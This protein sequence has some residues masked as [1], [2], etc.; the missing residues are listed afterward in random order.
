[1]S[2]KVKH[3]PHRCPKTANYS[4]QST[5]ETATVYTPYCFYD[6]SIPSNHDTGT[7]LI[8][9]CNV[10][11]WIGTIGQEHSCSACVESMYENMPPLRD[12]KRSLCPPYRILLS[13]R[14]SSR[15]LA[16]LDYSVLLLSS[17]FRNTSSSDKGSSP[18]YA[19][20]CYKDNLPASRCLIHF[21]ALQS[22]SQGATISPLVHAFSRV[23]LA[24]HNSTRCHDVR[25]I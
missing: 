7:P 9:H 20:H 2:R 14:R 3:I 6:L 12:L 24:P 10:S 13:L 1:M 18:T 5:T 17:F 19:S 21:D 11:P 22:R 16:S 23:R 8:E 25:R 15:L 4:R